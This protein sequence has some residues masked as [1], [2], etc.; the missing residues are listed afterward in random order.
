MNK[1]FSACDGD[2]V[3]IAPFFEKTNLFFDLLKRLM[4]GSVEAV[5]PPAV[6]VALVG[7]FEPSNRVIV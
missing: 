4:P 2:I 7:D 6:D 5:T 3:T 1:R